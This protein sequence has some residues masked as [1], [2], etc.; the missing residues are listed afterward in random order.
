MFSMGAFCSIY[1]TPNCRNW[2]YPLFW[3]PYLFL[4]SS[5]LYLS[6]AT[7]WWSIRKTSSH[8][9]HQQ[10]FWN[11]VFWNSEFFS[12]GWRIFLT[13]F[14]I[15]NYF[16]WK[17]PDLKQKQQQQINCRNLMLEFSLYVGKKSGSRK[18]LCAYFWD[19]LAFPAPFRIFTTEYNN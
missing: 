1:W 5:I 9:K 17:I 16:F 4:C 11:A 3:S 6:R 15:S 2:T 8:L 18:R 10:D 12:C 14:T 19:R 13:I 7:T